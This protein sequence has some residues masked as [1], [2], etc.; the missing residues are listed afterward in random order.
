VK[1][2]KTRILTH[3]LAGLYGAALT[4]KFTGGLSWSWW[5]VLSPVVVGL[6]VLGLLF[7]LGRLGR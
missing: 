6:A 4:L 3:I 5:I 7:L 2:L 1:N